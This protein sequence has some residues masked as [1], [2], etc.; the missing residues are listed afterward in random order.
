[1]LHSLL[2]R[3]ML[4]TVASFCDLKSLWNLSRASQKSCSEIQTMQKLWE[5]F[6]DEN[7][8]MIADTTTPAFMW[9][10]LGQSM[11]LEYEKKRE[12]GAA[13]ATSN[14][15]FLERIMDSIKHKKYDI[16]NL[17]EARRMAVCAER[18]VEM[19]QYISKILLLYA[20]KCGEPRTIQVLFSPESLTKM[21]HDP[22]DMHYLQFLPEWIYRLGLGSQMRRADLRLPLE[23]A[24]FY[25]HRKIV[26]F[27]I[28]A[29]ADVNS[30]RVVND[31]ETAVITPLSVAIRERHVEIV[32]TLLDAKANPNDPSHPL[33]RAWHDKHGWF[34]VEPAWEKNYITDMVM[35]SLLLVAKANPNQCNA[36]GA[37][38]LFYA[39]AAGD[40]AVINT[41]LAAKADVNQVILPKKLSPTAL[42]AAAKNCHISA[43]HA[44]FEA[45]A[46]PYIN[47]QPL[48]ISILSTESPWQREKRDPGTD[49]FTRLQRATASPYRIAQMIEY[50]LTVR[51]MDPNARNNNDESALMHA[52]RNRDVAAVVTLLA[53]GANC[54]LCDAAGRTALIW[55]VQGHVTSKIDHIIPIVQMLV[56]HGAIDTP[57]KQGQTAYSL[58]LTKKQHR[59]T[60]SKVVLFLQ[61][62]NLLQQLPLLLEEPQETTHRRKKA[63][64]TDGQ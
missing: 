32:Q 64:T 23:Y 60:Y 7:I 52:S 8:K 12:L 50:L 42:V 25:G 3:E 29:K 5:N 47:S 14:F 53:G 46:D 19:Y 13:I 56:A 34:V 21:I 24:V 17:L 2:P 43:V 27:C 10:L 30:R 31:G 22:V 33:L 26:Q 51:K 16:L 20:T 6:L 61:S 1:M 63:K 4:Y 40:V 48:L 9:K 57:N 38:P 18:N 39:A 41:L 36:E 58:A 54:N 37:S 62:F 45:H 59:K 44:L 49:T 35:A 15:P 28:H 11:S 55:A